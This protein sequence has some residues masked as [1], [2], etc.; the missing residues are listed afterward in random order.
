LD[1]KNKRLQD[2]LEHLP[3]GVYRTTPKGKIIEANPTLVEML[4]Y[5]QNSDLENINVKDLYAKAKDRDKHL[6]KLEKAPTG[7]SEF[8]IR[9]KDGSTLWCRDYPRAVKDSQGKILYYDGI[10]VDISRQ[11]RADEKLKKALR[12]LARSDKERRKMVKE[13]ENLSLQ[14]PL[15]GIY[16]LRGFQT[17]AREYLQLA[18]RKKMHMFLLYVDVDD[19]KNI[20]DTYGHNFGDKTLVSLVDIILNT[21]RKSDIKARVGGDEFVVFPIDTTK[22]G[23]EAAIARFKKNIELFNSKT[24]LPSPLSVSMGVSHYDPRRPFSVDE[25]VNK[26]DILMYQD[27]KRKTKR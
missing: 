8:Q 23:V 3:V 5:C 16:N 19:L 24:S 9:C 11:K 1:K 22:E 20:N 26:A 17:I 18:D 13:L 14:D 2:L 12:D 15:T 4:G 25:F 7:Y 21:F 10:L 6:K 27:K